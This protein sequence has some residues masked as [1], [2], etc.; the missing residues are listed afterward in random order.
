MEKSYL[1]QT[2]EYSENLASKNI[3][4]LADYMAREMCYRYFKHGAKETE[5]V[6][7]DFGGEFRD[8]LDETFEDTVSQAVNNASDSHA[9]DLRKRDEE[10]AGY[11]ALTSNILD[12]SKSHIRD[13]PDRWGRTYEQR[14]DLYYDKAREFISKRLTENSMFRYGIARHIATLATLT[15]RRSILS[16][17][18]TIESFARR[19]SREDATG[20]ANILRVTRDIRKWI[21]ENDGRKIPSTMVRGLANVSEAAWRTSTA[22]MVYQAIRQTM[23]QNLVNLIRNVSNQA[24]Q[25]ATISFYGNAPRI[26]ALRWVLSLSHRHVDIC[27][28]YATTD[29]GLGPGIWLVGYAPFPAHPNCMCELESIWDI[30]ISHVNI[31]KMQQSIRDIRRAHNFPEG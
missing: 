17:L 1:R 5:K 31:F 30:D 12:F 10:I 9:E 26:H 25:F 14:A 4:H 21:R 23:Y 29:N 7:S 2:D 8:V 22:V 13:L 18:D 11:V 15:N 20:R 19:M 24:Y 28:A 6:F 27:D 16:H 3:G